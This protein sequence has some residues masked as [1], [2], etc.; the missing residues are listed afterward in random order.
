MGRRPQWK[1]ARSR[2]NKASSH[3][4]K[5]IAIGATIGIVLGVAYLVACA[6]WRLYFG[7]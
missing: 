1:P 2:P 7:S 3:G 6:V 4:G 5:D